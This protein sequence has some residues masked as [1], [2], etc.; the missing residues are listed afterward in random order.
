MKFDFKKELKD[1]LT[2]NRDIPD[3]FNFLET[4]RHT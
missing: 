3:K 4:L 1:I 2:K